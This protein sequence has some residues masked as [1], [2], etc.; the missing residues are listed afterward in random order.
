MMVMN[1]MMIDFQGVTK[2]YGDKEAISNLSFQVRRGEFFGF[3]G[4]NGAGKT[5]SIKSMIGLVRP[6]EGS[7]FID[8]RDVASDPLRVRSIIGYVPDSPFVYGKLSAREFLVFVGGLYRM[9]PADIEKGITWLADIFD[10]HGWMDRRCEEYSHGMKQKVVMSAAFLHKPQ[11]IIVD[12]P[13]VGLDPPSRRLLKDML[14]MI[15]EHG[16]TVFMSSH[17][18]AEVEELCKRMAILHQ[19]SILAEGTLEDLRGK[20]ELEGGSLE[21]L[22]LKLTGSIRKTAYLE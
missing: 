12:E 20:A 7:I 8:G 13:T 16:T 15:Q 6:D 11:L 14:K 19:G 10:M 4:P 22:F 17:D 3:L 18:L 1:E 5:T 21:D 9:E 2:R